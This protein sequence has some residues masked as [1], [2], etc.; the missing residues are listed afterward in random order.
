MAIFLQA[1]ILLISG[2]IELFDRVIHIL[3]LFRVYPLSFI[4]L[5]SIRERFT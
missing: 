3:Y 5:Y 2:E 1:T 4:A